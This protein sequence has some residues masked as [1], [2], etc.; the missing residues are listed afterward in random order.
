MSGTKGLFG[1]GLNNDGTEGLF[2][3]GF[4][5]PPPPS[6]NYTVEV[7]P[8]IDDGVEFDFYKTAGIGVQFTIT[9]EEI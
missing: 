9:K 5:V 3:R 8:L 4:L 1:R 2:A 7:R 6:P